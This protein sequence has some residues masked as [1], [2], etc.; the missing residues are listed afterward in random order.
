MYIYARD[1]ER[2][3]RERERVERVERVERARE[4]IVL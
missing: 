4:R 2:G 1:R 3:S